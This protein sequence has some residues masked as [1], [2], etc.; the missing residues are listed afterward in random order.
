[1]IEE[2]AGSHP[3]KGNKTSGSGAKTS[4]VNKSVT[5]TSQKS[6]PSQQNNSDSGNTNELTDPKSK[7][8]TIIDELVKVARFG[9]TKED[10]GNKHENDIGEDGFNYYI[11]FFMNF[12][13]EYYMI[14]FSS[15]QNA[16]KETVY[17]I[18]KVE[19]RRFPN[20]DGSSS[21]N[22]AL[23]NGRKSSSPII[24]TTEDKSQEVKT[25]IQLAFEKA[26]KKQAEESNVE[27][28][29]TNPKSKDDTIVQHILIKIIL[30]IISK[31]LS[32]LKQIKKRGFII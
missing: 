13:G 18:G 2:N 6:N 10:I 28:S 3:D 29:L 4:D 14:S 31:K 25:A 20:R 32:H 12:D 24:Y 17:S 5:Q 22:G 26:F 30:L 11:A 27:N 1:M 16:N 19:K 15:A 21:K 7:D 9:T 23:K 8:D